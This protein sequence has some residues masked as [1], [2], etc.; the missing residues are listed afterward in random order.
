M[1]RISRQEAVEPAAGGLVGNG[2]IGREGAVGGG[3]GEE[4]F[5]G[6]A[7]VEGENL[8]EALGEFFV[9]HDGVVADGNAVVAE[10]AFDA[11]VAGDDVFAAI[12]KGFVN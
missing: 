10:P 12:G 11:A 1:L 5:E 6:N 7:F 3:A 8:A 4:P 9:A 2:E